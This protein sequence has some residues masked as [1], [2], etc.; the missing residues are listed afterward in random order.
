[1][2]AWLREQGRGF[3][4][5]E[6]RVPIVPGAILFDLLSGG[7]KNWGRYPPY[8]ELGYEAAKVAGTDFALGSAGAG[9]GATTVNLKGGIGSA[10]A[11]TRS[12]ITVGAIAAA[13]AA[14]SMTIGNSPHFWAAP[15]EQGKE[16][17]GRGWP[18]SFPAEALAFRSKGALGENTTLAVVATDARL[19]KAQAKR[20]AVMAQSGLSRAIYP[21]HTP[22]DGD[23]VFA[24]GLGVK[25][26]PDPVFA[27]SELGTL[28]ANVLARA[29]ARGIYEATA[30]A[31]PG[32]T[33]SWRDRFG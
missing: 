6:A 14:G 8:R 10:S 16:F 21:V 19:T 28:A 13:N 27:L 32:A 11:Q 18:A 31:F 4:V 20:L 1:V 17:G 24:A 2:Q 9:L 5:R 29:I 3:Q 25:P 30:L 7:D 33:P 15:F 12:G 22:L 23:V 26:L